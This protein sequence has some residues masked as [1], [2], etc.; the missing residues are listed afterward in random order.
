ME[1]K[2]KEEEEEEEEEDGEM[3]VPKLS[4]EMKTAGSR[5][6]KRPKWKKL[7]TAAVAHSDESAV[8]LVSKDTPPSHQGG[9]CHR[10][11]PSLVFA[12][13]KTFAK[14]FAMA[15]V[16]KFLQDLLSFASPQLLK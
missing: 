10:K 5:N 8:A 12:L 4:F 16:F 1:E 3:K 13:G 9:C 14:T 7:S 11:E 6:K 15:F 2:E